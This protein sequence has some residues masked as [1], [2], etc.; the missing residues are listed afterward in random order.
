MLRLR[1]L[2]APGSGLSERCRRGEKSQN[3][4]ACCAPMLLAWLSLSSPAEA[5][6]ASRA[7]FFF[8]FFFF[9]FYLAETMR[10]FGGC[11]RWSDRPRTM[12]SNAT[13]IP[14]C[15]TSDSKTLPRLSVHCARVRLRNPRDRVLPMGA[16]AMGGFAIIGLVKKLAFHAGFSLAAVSFLGLQHRLGSAQ[17]WHRGA[18]LY[19]ARTWTQSSSQRFAWKETSF[20]FLGE[21]VPALHR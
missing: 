6:R 15:A 4:R 14:C 16:R 7:S 3:P 2:P 13:K 12:I 1:G 20:E 18:A 19:G 5:I 11:G 9:F 17:D 21:L 8:V 10:N